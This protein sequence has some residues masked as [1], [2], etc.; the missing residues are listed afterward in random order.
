MK[1]ESKRK[2]WGAHFPKQVVTV[3]IRL[4]YLA[5][6]DRDNSGCPVEGAGPM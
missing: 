2:D 4:D 1:G 5:I 3:T 6:V